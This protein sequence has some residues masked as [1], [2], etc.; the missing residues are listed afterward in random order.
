MRAWEGFLDAMGGCPALGHW[1][2]GVP[3][4]GFLELGGARME[5]WGL[6]LPIAL[7]SAPP[8]V[9]WILLGHPWPFRALG[10]AYS[11]IFCALVSSNPLFC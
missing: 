10:A 8:G 6:V 3:R 7:W 5:S 11:L 1:G 4:L 9:S 2:L